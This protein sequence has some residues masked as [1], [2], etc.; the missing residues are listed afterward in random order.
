[1]TE[2]IIDAKRVFK[3]YKSRDVTVEA[4]RGI[5]I[6]V[7]PGE[8]VAVMG[9]SGS[10]KTTLLNCLSGLDSIDRRRSGDRLPFVARN[11]R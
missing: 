11:V 3:T 8:M 5:S 4:L 10:G 1:M 9:P 7:Q 2:P 6:A